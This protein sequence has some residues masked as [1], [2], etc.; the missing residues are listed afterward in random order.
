MPPKWPKYVVPYLDTVFLGEEV[1][2]LNYRL[3]PV[4]EE[5]KRKGYEADNDL[6][7]KVNDL[8]KVGF[9]IDKISKSGVDEIN[10]IDYDGSNPA[11]ISEAP[12]DAGRGKCSSAGTVVAS[13]GGRSLGYLLYANIHSF[14]SWDRP[15]YNVL[16]KNACLC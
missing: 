6:Q 10:D 2:T 3:S 15:R 9:I 7:V 4:Y 1:Q 12:F 14:N 8:A 16:S 11:F 5:G 13:A